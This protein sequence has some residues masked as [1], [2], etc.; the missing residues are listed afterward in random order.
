MVALTFTRRCKGA[1]N[2]AR[3]S[4]VRRRR[5]RGDAWTRV[6]TDSRVGV[7]RTLAEIWAGKGATADASWRR[8][9]KRARRSRW[10][11]H[12]WTITSNG[13]Q[14]P[15]NS[16]S[17]QASIPSNGIKCRARFAIDFAGQK[18]SY[19]RTTIV[20]GTAWE[21]SRAASRQILSTTM[22]LIT[23]N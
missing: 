23:A 21:L 17:G 1:R 2:G 4:K 3:G 9:R 20:R 8:G 19:R 14:Q 7:M 6:R 15:R 12:Q 22:N 13:C 10:L 16:S 18:P 11:P 5:R